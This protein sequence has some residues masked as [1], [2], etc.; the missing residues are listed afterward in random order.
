[1]K[2]DDWQKDLSAISGPQTSDR[3]SGAPVVEQQGELFRSVFIE[4]GLAKGQK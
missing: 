4:I 1:V 3:Q 2:T